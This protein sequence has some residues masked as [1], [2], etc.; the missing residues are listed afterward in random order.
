M[1][2]NCPN[3]WY[4]N[5]SCNVFRNTI[6]WT[7]TMTRNQNTEA[8]ILLVGC[9]TTF[10]YYSIVSVTHC[11]CPVQCYSLQY[12]PDDDTCCKL[13]WHKIRILRHEHHNFSLPV[14]S[15]VGLL[16]FLRRKWSSVIPQ[17]SVLMVTHAVVYDDTKP[18]P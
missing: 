13:R 2:R 10:N 11:K 15:Q 4:I 12:C 3:V 5:F 8:R 6:L 14:L 16:A 18:E 7:F 17:P 9:T 1:G